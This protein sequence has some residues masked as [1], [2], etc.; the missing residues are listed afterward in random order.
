MSEKAEKLYDGI[1][2]VRDDIVERSEMYVFRKK[3]VHYRSL[4]SLGGLVA[5]ACLLVM[6]TLP[7]L[8][9]GGSRSD[10]NVAEG[11]KEEAADRAEAPAQMVEDTESKEQFSVESA[12]EESGSTEELMCLFPTVIPDG[13]E[14]EVDAGVYE[15]QVLQAKYYNEEL[16]D[17]MMITIAH[18]DWFGEVEVNTVLYRERLE[19]T[20]SYI[21]IQG[22]EYIVEYS[23]SASDIA[24]MEEFYDIVYSAPFFTK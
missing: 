18:R 22:G 1:T 19:A 13:Y 4:L 17:E 24:E 8:A 10:C 5:C 12:T 16:Q 3:K 7:Q 9:G 23:F 15:G 11:V 2:G 14:M 6:I 21:F 20:G